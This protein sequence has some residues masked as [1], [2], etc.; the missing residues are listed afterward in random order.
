MNSLALFRA[1]NEV[2]FVEEILRI[3]VKHFKT[4][5]FLDDSTDGTGDIVRMFN[6]VVWSGRVPEGYP[7][8]DCLAQANQVALDKMIEDWGFP[9]WVTGLYADEILYH[10]PL[11]ILEEAEEKGWTFTVWLPMHF[12]LHTSQMENWYTEWNSRP[13]LKR[14]RWYCPGDTQI[15]WPGAEV[16]QYLIT[17]RKIFGPGDADAPGGVRTVCNPIPYPLYIHCGY[18]TPRQ[19]MERTFRNYQSASN[20]DHR[21]ILTQG[22]FLDCL[23]GLTSPTYFTGDF[24]PYEQPGRPRS[25]ECQH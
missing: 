18:R 8:R 14:L 9:F 5:Y 20:L 12:F 3:H 6:E 23:E 13:V 19:T 1:G 4:I 11:H 22:P 24:G 7:K 15:G 2:D 17:E 25:T 10:C 16:K 21:G